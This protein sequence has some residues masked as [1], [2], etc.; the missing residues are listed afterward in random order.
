M[1]VIPKQ[2][3][4]DNA[5]VSLVGSKYLGPHLNWAQVDRQVNMELGEGLG[6]SILHHDE[7]HPNGEIRV[8]HKIL[9]AKHL[10]VDR[11]LMTKANDHWI[12]L[13]RAHHPNGVL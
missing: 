9:L 13:K 2:M 10:E 6:E 5:C 1:L 3:P 4:L 7:P 8:G 12:Q 11:L